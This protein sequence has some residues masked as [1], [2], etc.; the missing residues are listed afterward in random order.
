MMWK[1]C[2]LLEAVNLRICLILTI[3]NRYSIEI[4]LLWPPRHPLELWA[5]NSIGLA[6]GYLVSWR[7][8]AVRRQKASTHALIDNL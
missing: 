3:E 2:G 4:R 7:R 6:V 8:N 1:K 5:V